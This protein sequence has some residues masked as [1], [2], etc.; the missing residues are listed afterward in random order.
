M[1]MKKVKKWTSNII[2]GIL[3]AVLIFMVVVVVSS[4]ASGGEP[5]AFG[6]QLKTVLSGSMEPGI[7]TGSIITVKPGGDMNRFEKGDVI[8]FQQEENMLVTHRVAEVIK[9]GDQVMY[10]TKGDNNKTEDLNPV[11]SENVVAEYTGFTVPYVGYFMNFTNSKN[12]AFLFIIPGIL[13]L[14]YSGFTIWRA[15]SQIEVKPK[16]TDTAEKNA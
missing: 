3:F 5:E 10:R 12:G 4:K 14:I 2:T 7:Q 16:K 9:N 8:T 15:I 1:N 6:Y 13:L 11:L